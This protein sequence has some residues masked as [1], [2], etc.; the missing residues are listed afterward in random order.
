L[1]VPSVW[2]ISTKQQFLA[3]KKSAD[4][5]GR[6]INNQGVTVDLYG[7][8]VAVSS[9]IYRD[10]GIEMANLPRGGDALPTSVKINTAD[11]NA[12][13][14]YRLSLRASVGG[15]RAQANGCQMQCCTRR[16]SA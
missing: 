4:I 10:K 14:A 16:Y 12:L 5:A 9:G 1:A 11:Q 6:Q 2:S 15:R 13:R 7:N 8:R 3:S